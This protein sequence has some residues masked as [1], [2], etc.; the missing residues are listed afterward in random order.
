M[1]PASGAVRTYGG[2]DLTVL[3][4]ELNRTAFWATETAKRMTPTTIGHRINRGG[5]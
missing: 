4:D 2:A 5:R 1:K 3:E